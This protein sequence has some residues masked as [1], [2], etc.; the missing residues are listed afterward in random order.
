[1]K[2]INQSNRYY[3]TFLLLVSFAM[4]SYATRP[5]EFLDRGLVGLEVSN[6]VFLSWRMLG[7]DVPDIGFNLYRNGAK[8]NSTPI[9]TSTN[10]I[11]ANGKYSDK[12]KVETII[13]DGQ[14]ETSAEITPWPRTAP[15][16]PDASGKPWLARMEIPLPEPP[17]E[18]GVVYTPGDMSVG[19][20]DGDGDY[21]I[22]FEWEGTI[23]YLEAIDLEG[24]SYWR[25]NCGPNTTYNGICPLI[26]D[27]DGDGKAE[28]ACKTG[29]GTIDGTGNYLSKGPASIDDDMDTLIR[30]SGHL[31]EDPSYITIFN[32]ETGQE[33]ATINYYPPIGAVEDMEETWGD[34]YGKRSASVKAAILYDKEKG[35]M[36]VFARGI[37]TRIAM[38]AYTWDGKQLHQQWLFD[39]EKYPEGQYYYEGSHSLAVADVDNDGSDEL[40]YGA[41]AIDNNGKGLYST[42]YHHGDS[43]ALGDLMPDRPGM[44]FFMPHEDDTHGLSMRDAATGEI[45]WEV[46]SPGDIGRAWAADVDPKYRGCEISSTLDSY[47]RDCNGDTIPTSYNPYFYPVYFDGDVQRELRKSDAVNGDSRLFTGW[48]YRATTIHSSKNDANLVAD[49]FGDWRE[50]I[51][52]K[53]DDDKAFVVFSTWI[54]TERKN[55]TLMH[56]PAYR[57]QIATQNVGYNQVANVSYYFAD[58]APIPDISLV[59]YNPEAPIVLPDTTKPILTIADE[60]QQPIDDDCMAYVPDLT[61]IANVS[62]EDYVKFYFSQL[63]VAGTLIGGVGE[64]MEVILKVND[65]YGNESE[66]ATVNVVATDLTAPVFTKAFD[67]HTLSVSNNCERALP[68][69]ISYMTAED[70]CSSNVTLS[71]SPNAGTKLN[72]HNDSIVVTVTADDNQGN[73]ADTSFTVKLIALDCITSVNATSSN[74]VQ[75]YPNPVQSVLTIEMAEASNDRTYIEIYSLSGVKVYEKTTTQSKSSCNL[76]A[77]ATGV[78]FLKAFNS[79][80]TYHTYF[81]KN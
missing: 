8:I 46:P 42:G 76:Q 12:Y 78:Y 16:H 51:I 49:I 41:C 65:G 64:N 6:G 35:P 26:Y 31:M 38:G 37:Y 73:V 19:D 34:T 25:I 9:T 80:Q 56:D 71:M 57:M 33:M 21:E 48:Y 14:N 40:M 69:Y 30:I 54:P 63:P 36:M 5:M 39:S 79:S 45:I 52:F 13:P 20:L 55:Y 47:N 72:G 74:V 2:K 61:N 32:G 15:S 1:M 62:D 70:N 17:V 27:F 28:M 50:E 67:D 53:R 59:K 44:E 77:L 24:H 4:N 81:I 60:F 11:D 7:T 18:N 22:I 68:N 43:H 29:P 10:Y 23:P 66:V 58:G 75:V 3:L